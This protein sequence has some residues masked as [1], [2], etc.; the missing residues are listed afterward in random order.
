MQHLEPDPIPDLP[1]IIHAGKPVL[2]TELLAR[3]YGVEP[4]IIQDGF[5]RNEQR[6]AAGFHYF[7]LNPGELRD[8]KNNP[9]LNGVVGR[10]AKGLRLWTERGAI[11][12]AKLIS[13]D[14]AWSAF[15]RL[16]DTYFEKVQLP[17]AP[18][19]IGHVIRDTAVAF[20]AYFGIARLI[21]QDR[22]QAAMSANRA[23]RRA[24]GIAPFEE[25]GLTHLDAPRQERIMTPSD[26]GVE[27]GGI[28]G[29]AVN[30]LLIQ[31][32][33][34]TETRDAKGRSVKVPTDKGQPFAVWQDTPKQHNDGT[35]VRQLKW[36]AGIAPELRK[37]MNLRLQ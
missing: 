26:I 13:T 5:E 7:D 32:G 1:A 8:L 29:R 37:A 22:N 28:S 9:A 12:H 36:S 34:Q 6:F 17:A 19:A 2:T 33:F 20:K 11:R 23:A 16:E 35:P 3:A 18:K 30:L 14:Q 4:K 10:N 31:Y 21:G 24:T 27:N 25:L 15:E